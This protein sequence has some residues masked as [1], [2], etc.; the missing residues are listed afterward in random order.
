MYRRFYYG[1]NM[2][3]LHTHIL[4]DIDD[5]SK[6]ISD[7]V[8]YLHKLKALGIKN[9]VLT[10]HFYPQ[11][12]VSSEML[13]R[14]D[15]AFALLKEKNNSGINLYL[16]SECYM[17]EYL[18]HA[19]ELG[20]LCIGGGKYLLTELS[21]DMDMGEKMLDMIYKLGAKYEVTP[22]LAHIERYPYIMK[23]EK[24]TEAFLE[25]GCLFQVNAEA[26]LNPFKCGKILKYLEKGYVHFL[27]TDT[28]REVMSEKSFKKVCD[29]VNKHMGREIEEV[30][31]GIEDIVNVK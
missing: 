22:I 19:Q 4:P 16:G 14:R 11:D 26:F 9:V 8:K 2:T 28:H 27:G 30:F 12:E 3:D 7:S 21:Y 1:V 18:F 17:H 6:N 10:P 24:M 31:C 5:G 29:I 23:N 15:A 25:A 13:K 20:P